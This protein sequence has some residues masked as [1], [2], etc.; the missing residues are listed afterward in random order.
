MPT[1]EDDLSRRLQ[2]ALERSRALRRHSQILGEMVQRLKSESTEIHIEAKALLSSLSQQF[3]QLRLSKKGQMVGTLEV[4]RQGNTYPVSYTYDRPRRT[5]QKH[6][7]CAS[8]EE[9]VRFLK[10]NLQMEVGSLNQLLI[11]LRQTGTGSI[12]FML[13]VACEGYFSDP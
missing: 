3:A 4:L 12:A 9:L 8:E 5:V 1:H 13:P 2:S 10:E 6:F 11:D 7:P